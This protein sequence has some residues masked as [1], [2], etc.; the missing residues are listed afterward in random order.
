MKQNSDS[1][2]GELK[3]WDLELPN[4]VLIVHG[5]VTH[6]YHLIR[7]KQIADQRSDF[8]KSR[9]RFNESYFDGQ[10]DPAQ[11]WMAAG[12]A[13]RY[14]AF[15]T[16]SSVDDMEFT[17]QPSHTLFIDAS[18]QVSHPYCVGTRSARPCREAP[19]RARTIARGCTRPLLHVAVVIDVL[20]GTPMTC[21]RMY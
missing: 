7:N 15:F 4:M 11:G 9:P 19:S 18:L 17:F 14:P 20:V 12:S 6:P 16:P 3:H 8:L 13:W 10:R 5:G 2:M 21:A 1:L